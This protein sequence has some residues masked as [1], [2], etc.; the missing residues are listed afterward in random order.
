MLFVFSKLDI[1]FPQQ[2]ET[3]CSIFKKSQMVAHSSN[4]AVFSAG[5]FLTNSKITQFLNK[6]FRNIHT[7][8]AYFFISLPCNLRI[9]IISLKLQKEPIY[10]HPLR[11]CVCFVFYSTFNCCSLKA[12]WLN[13]YD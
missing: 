11:L 1:P 13:F 2:F 12:S 9:E 6:H 4:L 10:L 8:C 7:V 5:I 3:I